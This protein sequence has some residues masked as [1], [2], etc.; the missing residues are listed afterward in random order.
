MS[1][2]IIKINQHLFRKYIS[3]DSIL[4]KIEVIASEIKSHYNGRDF[5]VICLLKGSFYI[6]SE[7]VQRL[8]SNIT[9]EFIKISSYEGM[10]QNDEIFI[11]EQ[12]F[13][14]HSKNILIIED[15]IDSGRTIRAFKKYLKK[16]N[17]NSIKI[18]TLLYKEKSNVDVDWYGFVVPDKFYIGFGLDYNQMYRN[19]S[20]IYIKEDNNEK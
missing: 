11:Q 1:E 18:F 6:F 14:I 13:D 7:L 4:N 2:N 12:N 8:P 16:N 17:P 5:V 20:S 15:I 9:F 19:L 10:K 3:R